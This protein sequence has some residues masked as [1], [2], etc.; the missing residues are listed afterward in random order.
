MLGPRCTIEWHFFALAMLGSLYRDNNAEP[1]WATSQPRAH[2]TRGLASANRH[3]GAALV[4]APD[5]AAAT[6]LPSCKR[7]RARSRAAGEC[8]AVGCGYL[9]PAECGAAFTRRVVPAP[10]GILHNGAAGWRP[11]RNGRARAARRLAARAPARLRYVGHPWV[12]P[13]ALA[14]DADGTNLSWLGG[15][16]RAR[17]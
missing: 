9:A 17:G 4:L 12:R 11:A 8:R 1:W 15:P 10:N 16:T 7:R 6:G 13:I 14:A 5:A 3:G 2:P